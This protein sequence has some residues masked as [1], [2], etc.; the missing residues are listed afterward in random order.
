M[1]GPVL[2]IALVSVLASLSVIASLIGG[3]APDRMLPL[4]L[5]LLATS[6]FSIWFIVMD[7][8]RRRRGGLGQFRENMRLPEYRRVS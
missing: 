2:L 4:L 5:P 7:P 8:T 6:A 3:S 1:R